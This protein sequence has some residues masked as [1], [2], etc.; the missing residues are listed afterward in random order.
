MAFLNKLINLLLIIILQ[1]EL[2]LQLMIFFFQD[3]ILSFATLKFSMSFQLLHSH[4]RVALFATG[5]ALFTIVEM[6]LPIFFISDSL[7]IVASQLHE[8]ALVFVL[9]SFIVHQYL[10]ASELFVIACD[11]NFG[12]TLLLKFVDKLRFDE[13]LFAIFRVRAFVVFEFLMILDAL[14]TSFCIAVFAH[15]WN[16]IKQMADYASIIKN[17]FF[18]SFYPILIDAF[19]FFGI[20]KDSEMLKNCLLV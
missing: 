17:H 19:F 3:S 10:V 16:I 11:L 5:R 6:S 15:Y 1:L 20:I 9:L 12:Q 7:A 13:F 8:I 4:L 18:V 2:S 14:S